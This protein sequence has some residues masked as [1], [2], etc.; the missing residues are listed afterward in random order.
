MKTYCSLCAKVKL[1][2]KPGGHGFELLMVV[3]DYAEH[4]AKHLIELAK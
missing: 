2:S 3:M 1:M 4:L